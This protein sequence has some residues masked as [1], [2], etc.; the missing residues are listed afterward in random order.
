MIVAV[1]G[2]F[3]IVEVL[4]SIRKPLYPHISC[5][6]FEALGR[7]ENEISHCLLSVVVSVPLREEDDEESDLF[8]LEYCTLPSRKEIDMYRDVSILD[9]HREE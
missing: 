3:K 9:K 7:A 5:Q 1:V 6:Y 4:N 2:G 8:S